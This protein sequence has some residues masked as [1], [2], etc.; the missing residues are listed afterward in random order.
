M[1]YIYAAT[2]K[3]S[4]G[5]ILHDG[6]YRLNH[7]HD[8]GL[9][10]VETYT[11]LVEPLM[12]LA[13]TPDGDPVEVH[14]LR[15]MAL[16]SDPEGQMSEAQLPSLDFDL[17][18]ALD[19]FLNGN[20]SPQ[21]VEDFG[22]DF[23]IVCVGE[24]HEL[25]IYAVTKV[26]FKRKKDIT[27]GLLTLREAIRFSPNPVFLTQEFC[28]Y[29]LRQHIDFG[30]LFLPAKGLRYSGLTRKQRARKRVRIKTKLAEWIFN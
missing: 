19:S 9:H 18:P 7:I 11:Y 28:S 5:D 13:E 30:T 12:A 10:E 21:I 24:M 26:T 8:A 14:R 20:P 2:K 23:L 6:P 3:L 29:S 15:I 25:P 16:L 27:A 17:N 4:P 22:R 1:D